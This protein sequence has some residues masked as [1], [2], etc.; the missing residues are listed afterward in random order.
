MAASRLICL[1]LLIASAMKAQ[2][3]TSWPEADKLFHT[4]PRWLG[5]DAAF[6]VDL[7]NNRVLWLFGDTWIAH[8]GSHSRRDASFLHNTVAIQNGYD[9]S[10]ASINFYW[11]ST[12]SDPHEILPN[13]G[14]VWMWPGAGIRAG[15]SLI[16]FAWRTTSDKSKDSLGFKGVG[17]NAYLVNN[18]DDEPTAWTLKKIAQQDDDVTMTCTVLRQGKFV[19]LFGQGGKGR[20]LYVARATAQHL[21]QGHLDPLAWWTGNSWNGTRTTR[22]PILHDVD[23]ET[24]IQPDPSGSGFIEINSQGFGASD[25]VMRR[26][27]SITGPWTAPK[28]I[29]RPPESDGPDAFV[30]AAKSHPELRGADLILTYATNGFTD[31]TTD[32]LTRYFPRFVRVTLKP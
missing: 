12:Q 6:S 16:L 10:H 18:P 4:D 27:P 7:G 22:Q 1:V 3:A 2:T 5:A 28:I 8:P 30:Y 9:P 21:E 29:Y 17:W 26:A 24:S 11:R 15:N 19:Y 31:A 14:D 23:T 32:D 20:D 13:E 25:I